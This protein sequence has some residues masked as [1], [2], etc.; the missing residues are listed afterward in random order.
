MLAAAAKREP[1][2]AGLIEEAWADLQQL[3][4]PWQGSAAEASPDEN[5]IEF[6]ALEEPAL[7]EEFEE[8]PAVIAPADESVA[9]VQP[10]CYQETFEFGPPP[11]HVCCRRHEQPVTEVEATNLTEQLDEI[12]LRVAAVEADDKPILAVGQTGE[13]AQEIQTDFESLSDSARVQ[14]AN[15]FDE[16]FEQEE[17]VIDPYARL[18]AVSE[19]SGL[20]DPT[21]QEYE[22][23]MA[24][25]AIFQQSNVAMQPEDAPIAETGSVDIGEDADAATCDD[26]AAC[27]DE[28]THEMT[29]EVDCGADDQALEFEETGGHVDD[30]DD[31]E[32]IEAHVIRSLPPDDNDLIV[33][34]DDE[35][36]GRALSSSAGKAHRQEYRQLFSKLRDG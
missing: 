32:I 14:T 1:V 30:G 34:V 6:G 20:P 23:A 17:I 11:D 3:P 10:S 19:P 28:T 26:V 15:P 8:E 29:A 2:D 9:A 5:V 12:E 22:L 24:T 31:S 18:R 35:Q 21:Q 4:A 36:D 16:S 7:E 25:E 33:V 13:P 27:D